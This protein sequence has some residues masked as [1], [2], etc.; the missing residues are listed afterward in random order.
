MARRVTKEEL[1]QRLIV[2]EQSWKRHGWDL[3]VEVGLAHKFGCST[4]TVRRYKAMVRDMHAARLAE[5]DD[6]G[7]AAEFMLRLEGGAQRALDEGRY[8]PWVGA[9]GVEAK[10]RGLEAAH[11]VEV[12]SGESTQ[13]VFHL[14]PP[15]GYSGPG[16][17]SDPCPHCGRP[18]GGDE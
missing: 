7:K 16:W 6:E 5:G 10:V 1:Q 2:V 15:G 3:R 4:R 18:I 9:M 12:K 14:P 8:G 11:K 13:V 17:E